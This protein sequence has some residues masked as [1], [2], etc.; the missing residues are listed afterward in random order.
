MVTSSMGESQGMTGDK[1]QGYTLRLG[2]G[3]EPVGLRITNAGEGLVKIFDRFSPESGSITARLPSFIEFADGTTWNG[4]DIQAVRIAST[5]TWVPVTFEGTSAAEVITGTYGDDTLIGAGGAD[6]MVASPGSDALI[7]SEASLLVFERGSGAER[8]FM[9]ERA[10]YTLR[11]GD[12]ILP[13]D[14]SIKSDATLGSGAPATFSGEIFISQADEWQGD[15]VRGDLPDRIEFA[16]GTVWQA[17]DFTQAMTRGTPMDDLIQGD[18][19]DDRLRGLAG[20]DELQGGDGRDTLH[21]GAGRDTLRG[22]RGDDILYGADGDVDADTGDVF[23]IG[24]GE[25]R[26]LVYG[27]DLDIVDLS[28]CASSAIVI[29]PADMLDHVVIQLAGG[30]G[31]A[32]VIENSSQAAGLI[33]QFRDRSLTLAELMA[34]RDRP[35]SLTLT[36][37]SRADMLIGELGDDTILAQSGNDT[38]IGG[39]GNDVLNGGRG[40]DTYLF[41]AGD[42]RDTLVDADTSWFNT[43]VLKING[44]T[45]SQLWLSREGRD[46]CV[47]II[48]TQDGVTIKNWYAGSANQIERITAGDGKSLSS[49]RVNAM[50][51]AMSGFAPPALGQTTLAPD[52][53]LALNKV[54]SSH[55]R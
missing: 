8:V 18:A 10:S 16:G 45:S 44:A 26:D 2:A 43:D 38:L 40:N 32:V 23:V 50:V 36:G 13:D 4:Y 34:V 31:D 17:S 48:G 14:V 7:L 6:T 41:N 53:T 29:S 15:V 20:Q 39:G 54:L 35:P 33:V 52:V 9:H 25:G 49:S 28:W 5:G 55:W 19:G 30:A 27:S 37:T 12:G 3:F 51:S 1:L 42:G 22:G 21:G 24:K 47:S 11:L 46:L